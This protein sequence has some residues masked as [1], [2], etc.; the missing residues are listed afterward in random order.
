M[1]A[2][3]RGTQARPKQLIAKVKLGD[4][5]CWAGSE[6]PLASTRSVAGS[7]VGQGAKEMTLL[8]Y[9]PH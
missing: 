5:L 6:Q 7:E 9:G 3:D 8:G 1:K 4:R 2:G